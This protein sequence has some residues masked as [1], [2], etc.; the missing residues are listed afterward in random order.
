M[1]DWF[2]DNVMDVVAILPDNSEFRSI[3]AAELPNRIATALVVCSM[4]L[5]IQ[6]ADKKNLNHNNDAENISWYRCMKLLCT[7]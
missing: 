7:K 2:Y 4:S 3:N 5:R 6:M 1:D